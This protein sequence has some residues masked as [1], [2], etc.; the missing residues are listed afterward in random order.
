MLC[1]YVDYGAYGDHAGARIASID[2]DYIWFCAPKMLLISLTV[3]TGLI[4]M[5]S[6][7]KKF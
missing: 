3:V 1:C 6:T 2:R 7:L 4:G 5:F